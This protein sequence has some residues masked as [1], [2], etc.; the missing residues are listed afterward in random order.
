MIPY[1][2]LVIALT[3][4]RA[5]QGLPVVSGA[6]PPSA[7]P[8]A[9]PIAV[10]PQRATP[11]TPPARGFVANVVTPPPL[12]PAETHEDVDDAS[13]IE[14]SHYENEGDDFAMAFGQLAP[15]AEATAI[16]LPPPP[17]PSDTT[18]ETD[19]QSPE[20]AL[21]A[22][23]GTVTKPSSAPVE[24]IALGA[25]GKTPRRGNNDDW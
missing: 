10:T 9:P 5:R 22:P 13:L 19:I 8:V 24:D 4:W 7:R 3:T 1:D 6:L 16:G 2:D 21:G 12:A 23:G 25:P 15:E 17:R 20:F 11:P 18:L 14:E